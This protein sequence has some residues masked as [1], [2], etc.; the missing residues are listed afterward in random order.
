MQ[1]YVP[2]M[3]T[4]NEAQIK[5]KNGSIIQDSIGPQSSV[6]VEIWPKSPALTVYNKNVES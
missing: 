4:E 5:I 2:T 3:W 6:K 1:K